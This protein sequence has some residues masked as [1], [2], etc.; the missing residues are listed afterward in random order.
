MIFRDLLKKYNIKQMFVAHELG[1]DVRNLKRYDDLTTR[2]I[3]EVILIHNA[4]KIPYKELIGTELKD[5]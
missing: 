3:N 5:D 1:I 4:T 2:S